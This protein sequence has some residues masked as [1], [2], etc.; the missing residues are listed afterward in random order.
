MFNYLRAYWQAKGEHMFMRAVETSDRESAQSLASNAIGL[1]VRAS[2]TEKGAEFFCG[3]FC[4]S[5]YTEIGTTGHRGVLHARRSLRRR[6]S[7]GIDNH[8]GL[9]RLSGI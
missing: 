2:E 9:G 6:H 3:H 7:L 4:A 5:T 8:R 1:I